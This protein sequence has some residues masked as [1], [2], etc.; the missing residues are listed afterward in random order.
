MPIFSYQIT[1]KNCAKTV[2][3]KK[4]N[5]QGWLPEAISACLPEIAALRANDIQRLRLER[6]QDAKE[7]WVAS[8]HHKTELLSIEVTK[9]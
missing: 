8:L 4:S 9:I 7:K 1:Y 5:P 6:V 3:L 2:E